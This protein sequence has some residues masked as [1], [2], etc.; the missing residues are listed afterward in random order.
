GSRITTGTDVRPAVLAEEYSA[1]KGRTAMVRFAILAVSSVL[2]LSALPVHAQNPGDV[3]EGIGR[4]LNYNRDMRREEQWRE[5][6][7][8]RAYWREQRRLEV[9]Q[10]DFVA[11]LRV[12]D[13]Q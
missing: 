2:A 1:A 10:R 13:I 8:Q 5:Q 9:E 12:L 3:L 6:E 11:Q 4:G 7:R